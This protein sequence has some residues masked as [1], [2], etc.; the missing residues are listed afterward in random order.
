MSTQVVNH[1]FTGTN[2]SPWPSPWQTAL[3]GGSTGGAIDIQSNRGRMQARTEL[4]TAARGT[5]DGV[6][7]S[8]GQ[9]EYTFR[10][11]T[12]N[13]RFSTWLW[14]RSSG[15]WIDGY[16]RQG[17]YCLFFGY[18]TE[19]YNPPYTDIAIL[20]ATGTGASYL[21][22]GE[23]QTLDFLA[24]TDYKVKVEFFDTVI[25][26]KVWRASESE[27]GWQFSHSN[28]THFSSGG[29]DLALNT[30]GST[31][32][33]R[34]DFDDFIVTDTTP[35]EEPPPP[36]G[37]VQS[38]WTSYLQA[39]TDIDPNVEPPEL[40]PSDWTAYIEATTDSMPA[41]EWYGARDGTLVPMSMVTT[42]QLQ[43]GS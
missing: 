33:K 37:F 29:V 7:L 19:Y 43:G 13:T 2:G 25:R 10:V 24:N 3:V 34:V 28:A 32:T 17:G 20:R 36:G 23:G 4:N 39:S 27:P 5:L 26:G 1:N 8:R 15:S 40:E 38:D 11:P 18:D 22:I 30:G 31:L 21:T 12:V 14:F 6:L 9:I 35:V 42:D 41:F 16:T